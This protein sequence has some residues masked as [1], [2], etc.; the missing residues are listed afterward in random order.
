MHPLPLRAK[1]GAAQRRVIVA[2]VLSVTYCFVMPSYALPG[3]SR[4]TGEPCAACHAG[5][6][7]AAA[8]P[9]GPH[10]HDRENWAPLSAM[11]RLASFSL[12]GDDRPGGVSRHN[13][14]GEQY[15]WDAILG[16]KFVV[17]DTAHAPWNALPVWGF[18]GPQANLSAER[19]TSP[20]PAPDRPPGDQSDSLE[21]LDQE[22]FSSTSWNDRSPPYWHVALRTDLERHFLQIGTFER[23][24]GDQGNGAR[25]AG[26]PGVDPNGSTLAA[27]GA[28]YRFVIDP[29]SDGRDAVSVHAIVISQPPSPSDGFMLPGDDRLHMLNAFRADAAY[30]IG[31]TVTPSI[32]YFRTSAGGEAIQYGWAGS[33]PNSA[34]VI[35][36]VSYL[37]WARSDSPIQ[38]LNLRFAAQ[39]VA[40]TEVAQTPRGP[41]PNSALYL[42]LWG[43]LHF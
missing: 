32:Q 22:Q 37:P 20:Y 18:P 24:D 17:A 9:T 26:S 28:A 12:S 39:Y 16:A 2:L 23:G 15:G 40:Y 14:Q 19:F 21:R 42:S 41:A 33:R 31:D 36:A 11:I 25:I 38:S 30:G 13:T 3:F 1:Q 43:A 35:A 27:V 10:A 29:A 8:G 6:L 34:G 4:Q 5:S 7:G